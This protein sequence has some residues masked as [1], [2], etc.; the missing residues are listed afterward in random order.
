LDIK[1]GAF[2]RCND[3]E[4][5]VLPR[6]MKATASIFDQLP[7]LAQLKMPF[8]NPISY[9]FSYFDLYDNL[10]YTLDAGY[11]SEYDMQGN[12]P[13][14]LSEIEMIGVVCERAM[15]RYPG[16]FR[17]KIGKGVTEV[18]ESA[19]YS[20]HNMISVEFADTVHTIGREAFQMAGFAE[21]KLPASLEKMGEYAFSH[22]PNLRVV[23]FNEKLTEIS[24]AA[25][26]KCEALTEI[27]LPDGMKVIG[28]SAFAYCTSLSTVVFSSSLSQIEKDAFSN[29]AITELVLPSTL[30]QLSGFGRCA[31]LKRVDLSLCT[32]LKELG[33]GC[34]ENCKQLQEVI[35]PDTVQVI[36][37]FTFSQCVNLEKINLPQ[38]LLEIDIYAFADCSKLFFETLPNG[39]RYVGDG[40][41]KNVAIDTVYFTVDMEKNGSSYRGV[42]IKH[43]VV[44]EG[45]TVI[46]L[47][48]CASCI[49][50]ESVQFPSTLKTIDVSAFADCS[51]LT[52]LTFPEGLQ[53]IGSRAF[54][55]SGLRS[56]CLPAGLTYVGAGAFHDC[57]ALTE[58]QV[59]CINAEMG[60]D[61][62]KESGLVSISFAPGMTEIP[63]S[64]CVSC[65]SLERV[66]IPGTVTFVGEDAFCGDISLRSIDFSGARVSLGGG[67]FYG[68]TLL[69]ELKN[70]T[71][72]DYAYNDFINS[73]LVKVENGMYSVFGH[74]LYVKNSEL[75]AK[76]VIPSYITHIADIAFIDCSNLV[77]LEIP[78]SVVYIGKE[79]FYNCYNLSEVKIG[80]GLCVVGED[81][82]GIRNDNQRKLTKCTYDG[83]AASW[84]SIEGI[85][86]FPKLCN[87]ICQD[88]TIL[89]V[90]REVALG[91][92]IEVILTSDGVAVFSGE[93]D[94]SNEQF[95]WNEYA[96]RVKKVILLEGITAVYSN[97]VF[98]KC[99][100]LETI[101]FPSTMVETAREAFENTLWYQKFNSKKD[102]VLMAGEALLMVSNAWEGTFK[103]P[104]GIKIVSKDAF[105]G[106]TQITDVDLNRVEYIGKQAFFRCL[107]LTHIEI[108]DSV[109]EIASFAF[110]ACTGLTE[111]IIPA[112][113]TKATG[114][115]SN[116]HSLRKLIFLGGTQFEHSIAIGCDSL[117]LVVLGEGTTQLPIYSVQNCSALKYLVL[118][119]TMLIATTY[120]LPTETQILCMTKELADFIKNADSKHSVYVYSEFLPTEEGA[121]W[122]YNEQGEPEIYG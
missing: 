97:T 50:L 103:V 9:Y 26:S 96:D 91:N 78:D 35:L 98:Q 101:V 18:G 83:T 102:G 117:E 116:C 44:R 37:S 58:A 43:L 90:L 49:N 34:F 27:I 122:H 94:I 72:V 112:G 80:N 105:S 30:T 104:D 8:E 66:D 17:L 13:K 56:V 77:Y 60:S 19:F 46:P 3:L 84:K 20:C 38:G 28:D 118:P 21:L 69:N 12:V 121:F 41:F 54:A 67:V 76:T 23:I 47:N 57:Q 119:S 75:Y 36:E 22:N 1:T 113:V 108:P 107:G 51:M 53:S 42:L 68:C 106:C 48:L 15:E 64:I 92:G 95:L 25:F 87:V 81:A 110:E 100:N 114:I 55:R 82:F 2:S 120:S 61:I 88:T 99:V 73:P 40:A 71:L 45:V 109:T 70:V 7:K 86:N 29:T 93:G 16:S 39:I 85:E 5:I 65:E 33:S 24:R 59:L 10:Y 111:L 4:S 52:A 115:V 79:A 11:G 63:V 74:I 14:S 32:S 89:G 62:F 6:H 31:S